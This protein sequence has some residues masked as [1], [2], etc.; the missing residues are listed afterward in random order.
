MSVS[1]G[2]REVRRVREECRRLPGESTV[3]RRTLRG[4]TRRCVIGILRRS[5]FV[6]VT[7]NALR[8]GSAKMPICMTPGTIDR[9]MRAASRKFRLVVI[10]ALAP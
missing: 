9:L 8:R 7:G 1:L 3:T 5:I 10:E 4:E 2:N 6:H